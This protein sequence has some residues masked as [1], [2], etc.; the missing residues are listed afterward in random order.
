MNAYRKLAVNASERCFE[1][2]ADL[3]HVESFLHHHAKH[4]A[5]LAVMADL[6]DGRI[7]GAAFDSCDIAYPDSLI[8]GS[9]A[10]VE[11]LVDGQNRALNI[12]P[13]SPFVRLNGPRWR[14]RILPCE[15]G[16]DVLRRN[17]ALGQHVRWN[18][19]E[20]LFVLNP[21]QVDFAYPVDPQQDISRVLREISQF[22]IREAAAFD[23]VKRQVGVAKFIV[24]V[25]SKHPF[26][27]SVLDIAELLADLIERIAHIA[28]ACLAA[29]I[30][31][32]DRA[33]RM[34]VGLHIIELRRFLDLPLDLV[35]DL[36]LQFAHGCTR[37][38]HLN[39]HCTEREVRI[40]LL[41]EIFKSKDPSG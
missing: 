1:L 9:D 4:D 41:P 20:D 31:E 17:V 2:L 5:F 10:E 39:D 12:K 19:D 3:D 25:R 27:Q 7:F 29:Q 6:G 22:R 37:P 26:R 13:Y 32:D 35:H 18:F 38:D 14:L 28:A 16:L 15:R 40:F 11:N 36:L 21:E 33:P 30:D 8:S 34:G 23:R 24:E